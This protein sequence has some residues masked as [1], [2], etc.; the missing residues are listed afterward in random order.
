MEDELH[1]VKNE[2]ADVRRR[3][4]ALEEKER[5][6]AGITKEIEFIM[7]RIRLMEKRIGFLERVRR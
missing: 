2:L 4:E 3:V 7:D 1:F 6:E 5:G